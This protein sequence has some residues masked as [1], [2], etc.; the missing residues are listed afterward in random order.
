MKIDEEVPTT[1]PN[2]IASAQPRI[3]AGGTPL[4]SSTAEESPV[5]MLRGPTV[6]VIDDEQASRIGLRRVLMAAG[7]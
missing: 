1:V 4:V 5:G 7:Y 3:V 2:M 6:L